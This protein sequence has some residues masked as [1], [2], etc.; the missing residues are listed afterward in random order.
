MVAAQALERYRRYLE[1]VESEADRA[2]GEE[3]Y[4]ELLDPGETIDL[5]CTR[6][7]LAELTLG[8][9]QMAELERLDQLLVKHHRLI[10]GNVPPSPDKPPSRWWWH[11]HQ[12]PRVRRTGKPKLRRAG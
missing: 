7:Q 1:S 3:E 12:G 10:A 5:L 6:D 9:A 8:E 4:F 11:L 2:S